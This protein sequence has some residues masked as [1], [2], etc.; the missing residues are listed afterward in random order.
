MRSPAHQ[1]CLL[2]ENKIRGRESK[3]QLLRYLKRA[4]SAM[5]EYAIVPVFLTLEGDDPSPEATEAGYIPVG[6]LEVLELTEQ[7]VAQHRARIPDDAYVFLD[8]YLATV[9]R[10]IMQDQELIELCK[11]KSGGSAGLSRHLGLPPA[12][13]GGLGDN[14]TAYQP[15]SPGLLDEPSGTYRS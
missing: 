15:A 2:I 5:P 1:F 6:Y 3:G 9:R 14:H 4:R 8:H 7:I 11:I 13:A 10:L 12:S